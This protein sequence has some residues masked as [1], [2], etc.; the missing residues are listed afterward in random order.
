MGRVLYELRGSDEFNDHSGFNL[1]YEEKIVAAEVVTDGANRPV[2][3][4]FMLVA[5]A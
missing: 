2:S 5:V 3:L 1:Q 4:S